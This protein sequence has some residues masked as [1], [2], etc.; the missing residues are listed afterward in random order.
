MKLVI[1]ESQLKKIIE[2]SVIGAPNYGTY[3]STRPNVN[4]NQ[5]YTDL[6]F[7]PEK[8]KA[9]IQKQGIIYPDVA[10]AQATWETGHFSS[11]IFK[12]NNNLF[13]MKL[14]HQRKTTAIGQNRGH[15]KYANWQDSVKD[16]KL[17]QDS[18]GM[19]NLPKNQYITKL[20]D[21]YCSPPDCVRG[22][23]GKNIQKM[24]I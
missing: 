8:L 9:E 20:S 1:S 19:S 10:F 12:E 18:N 4:T 21:I 24:L 5:Q 16:Y 11:P 3:N 2:Q 23:Y 17:W 14:A 13:G 15:A 6:A 7:S 22:S